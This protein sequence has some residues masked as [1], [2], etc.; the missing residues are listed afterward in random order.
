LQLGDNQIESYSIEQ[1]AKMMSISQRTAYSLMAKGLG[2][3]SIRVGRH[4][5]ITKDEFDK[6]IEAKQTQ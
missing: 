6:W 5:R 3:A 2:P 4:I 1:F